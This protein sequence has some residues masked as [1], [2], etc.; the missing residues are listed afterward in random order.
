MLLTAIYATMDGVFEFLSRVALRLWIVIKPSRSTRNADSL[1]FSA[2]EGRSIRRLGNSP[3]IFHSIAELWGKGYLKGVS[4][5]LSSV[6]F[7]D[8]YM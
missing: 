6:K 8:L 4:A 7:D 2:A 1:F 3:V 5:A